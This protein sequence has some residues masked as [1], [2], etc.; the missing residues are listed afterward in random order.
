MSPEQTFSQ[1]LHMVYKQQWHEV[2]ILEVTLV[3]M[4]SCRIETQ[5]KLR[6][7]RLNHTVPLFFLQENRQYLPQH[8]QHANS[9]L[10]GMATKR[11]QPPPP[12]Y[13]FEG[14]RWVGTRLIF[15]F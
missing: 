6:K 8:P 5:Q 9:I 2:L 3:N 15:F 11:G 4:K 1:T 12:H 13:P 10:L 7:T 14:R